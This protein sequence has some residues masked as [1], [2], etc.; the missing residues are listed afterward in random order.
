MLDIFHRSTSVDLKRGDLMYERRHPN[1]SILCHH[2]GML[3]HTVDSQHSKI[4]L[5]IIQKASSYK[6]ASVMGTTSIG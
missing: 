3:P 4:H 1:C 5:R 6:K 2:S